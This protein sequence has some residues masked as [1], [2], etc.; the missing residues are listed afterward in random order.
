[1]AET[2]AVRLIHD[3]VTW[4]RA[5]GLAHRTITDRAKLLHRLD[6]DL[7]HGLLH[8][9]EA[10]LVEWLAGHGHTNQTTRTY[11]GHMRG[12][13]RWA[14]IAGRLTFDPTTGLPRPRVPR[15]TPRPAPDQLLAAILTHADTR[16]RLW[17]VLA[18]YAGLRCCEIATLHREDCTRNGVLVRG[19]GGKERMVPMHPRI[20]AAV[21]PLP[22]GPVA[23][24]PAHIGDPAA[25]VS[26]MFRVHLQR[27]LGIRRVGLHRLRV[28]FA[29]GTLR[30]CHDLRTVQ[31]LLGHASPET[32][33]GY[34]LVLVDQLAGAVAALPDLGTED[35]NPNGATTRII[36]DGG[37]P[38]SDELPRIP[39]ETTC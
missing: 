3:H 24:I 17:A 20:W 15:R 29:T 28:W 13:Y 2:Y 10:E 7:P 22:P 21:K 14:T 18:A 30:Q 38:G 34:T 5:A 26:Q 11:G 12:F 23:D 32:T 4:C 9:C 25:Y 37:I 36:E 1:M 33:A 35:S 31:E 39:R 19:K 27:R 8:A 16:Y 6:R